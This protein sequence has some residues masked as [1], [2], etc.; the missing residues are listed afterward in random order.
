MFKKRR[1]SVDQGKVL[2]ALLTDLSNALDCLDHSIV[3]L[4]AYD[5][6]LPT[7]RLIHDYLSNKKQRTM[8]S[9]SYSD[10]LEVV[11]GVPQGS[12]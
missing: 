4:N 11:F 6:S 9:N 2:A 8:M 7:S 5:I 3:K 1:T 12:V 10:W